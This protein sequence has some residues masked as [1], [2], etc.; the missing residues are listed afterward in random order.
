[1][2]QPIHS[3][4]KT[5]NNLQNNKYKP[6]PKLD[7]KNEIFEL[8]EGIELDLDNIYEPNDRIKSKLDLIKY[9]LQNI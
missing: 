3:L 8:L 7:H 5:T 9:H 2:I 1:M 4:H 6:I